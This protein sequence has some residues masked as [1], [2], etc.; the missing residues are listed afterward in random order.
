MAQLSGTTA[1]E[2]G[3]AVEAA[4]AAETAEDA[5]AREDTGNEVEATGEAT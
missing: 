5:V 4:E 2:A 3:E 1:V